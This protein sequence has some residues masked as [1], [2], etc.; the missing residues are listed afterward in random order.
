MSVS[1]ERFGSTLLPDRIGLA[2]VPRCSP[3]PARAGSRPRWC[4]SRRD[5]VSTVAIG[6][7]AGSSPPDSP[8]C[9]AS[10]ASAISSSKTARVPLRRGSRRRLSTGFVLA[11][12]PRGTAAM[13]FAQRLRRKSGRRNVR[14]VRLL[15]WLPRP[16]RLR[17]TPGHRCT[18]RRCRDECT[19]GR[20]GRGRRPPVRAVADLRR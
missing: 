6:D 19:F 4:F 15:A 12:R 18:A 11:I 20:S 16:Q 2:P 8:A 1:R 17:S 14:L 10:V 3:I 9:S 13:P 7:L 5:A